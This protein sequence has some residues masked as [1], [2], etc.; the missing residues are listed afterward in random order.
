MCNFAKFVFPLGH[1]LSFEE[2][3]GLSANVFGQFLHL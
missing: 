3:K 1:Y 2:I